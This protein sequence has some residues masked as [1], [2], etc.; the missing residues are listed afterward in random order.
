MGIPPTPAA[1]HAFRH[2]TLIGL[3]LSQGAQHGFSS[4]LVLWPRPSLQSLARCCN[5]PLFVPL[6]YNERISSRND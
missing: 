6:N 1:Y 5:S 4:H 3:F 2:L